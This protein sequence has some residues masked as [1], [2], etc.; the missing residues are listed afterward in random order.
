MA[1]LHPIKGR[2][3]LR[4]FT[5]TEGGWEVPIPSSLSALAQLA[6]QHMVLKN[7]KIKFVRLATKAE[8]TSIHLLRDGDVLLVQPVVSRN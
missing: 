6:E 3:I 7:T 2:V 8:L 4:H 1:A 5:E